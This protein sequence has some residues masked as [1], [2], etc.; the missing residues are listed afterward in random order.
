MILLSYVE[1]I[2]SPFRLLAIKISKNRTTFLQSIITICQMIASVESHMIP[3]LSKSILTFLLEAKGPVSI[4]V[5][6][7][8][9]I[10]TQ[11]TD[12]QGGGKGTYDFTNES[13]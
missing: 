4:A 1:Q 13:R 10:R 8:T 7:Y 12:V 6:N 11:E 3:S 2:S 5:S 9:I